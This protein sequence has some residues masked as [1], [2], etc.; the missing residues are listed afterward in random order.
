MD[1][2]SE[3]MFHDLEQRHI[4]L[5]KEHDVVC[6]EKEAF[7][8]WRIVLHI[9]MTNKNL[10]ALSCQTEPL[11]H[12]YWWDATWHKADPDSVLNIQ[13]LA[14]K[15]ATLQ[16]EVDELRG[17]LVSAQ[18]ETLS[19]DLDLKQVRR[20]GSCRCVHSWGRT[21]MSFTGPFKNDNLLKKLLR[22]PLL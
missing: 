14:G 6:I 10:I 17:K 21:L 22:S 8:G 4:L 16:N 20:A 1:G 11:W 15:L 18:S 12:V 7:K 3:Q 19:R 2:D 13:T 5:R 9:D